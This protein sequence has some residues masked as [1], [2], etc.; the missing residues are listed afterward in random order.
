MNCP[1]EG[2]NSKT[3]EIYGLLDGVSLSSEQLYNINIL[4]VSV[5]NFKKVF[6]IV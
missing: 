3:F 4:N 1:Y 5:L 6:F 2:A